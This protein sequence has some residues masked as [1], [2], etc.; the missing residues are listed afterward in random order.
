MQIWRNCNSISLRKAAS[1]HGYVWRSAD[2]AN[3]LGRLVVAEYFNKDV[4]AFERQ[5]LEFVDEIITY[6]RRR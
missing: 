2:S 6:G 5:Y 1:S 3:N 4:D